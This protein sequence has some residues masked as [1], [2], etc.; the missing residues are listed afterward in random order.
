MSEKQKSEKEQA[1]WVS[2]KGIS[3][4]RLRKTPKF[5]LT[6]SSLL[7]DSLATKMYGLRTLVKLVVCFDFVSVVVVVVVVAFRELLR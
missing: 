3:S 4:P 2:L 1:F 5:I 7:N 6:K